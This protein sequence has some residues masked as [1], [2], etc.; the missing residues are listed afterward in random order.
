M[1]S[2]KSDRV[3]ILLYTDNDTPAYWFLGWSSLNLSVAVVSYI[4]FPFLSWLPWLRPGPPHI[5][6]LS[7]W[8]QV[9]ADLRHNPQVRVLPAAP[10]LWAIYHF[11]GFG[12]V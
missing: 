11:G 2:S 4:S 1:G 8:A 5:M 12:N 9:L 6:Q 3:A 7:A 10:A